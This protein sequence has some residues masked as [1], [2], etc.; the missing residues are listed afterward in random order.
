[1]PR[2][3]RDINVPEPGLILMGCRAWDSLTL[4]PCPVCGDGIR[5]G[6]DS[7]YCA[8]CDSLSPRMESRVL[9]ARAALQARLENEIAEQ[10][11]RVDLRRLRQSTPVLSEI[12]RRR[13]WMGY[14]RNGINSRNPEVANRAKVGRDWL[15]S[16]GQAP[17]WSILLDA[18]GRPIRPDAA[19][20]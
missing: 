8:R 14:S 20:A 5:K 17:D 1:M 9:A 7:T 2:L 13:L 4:T 16:I 15:I 12:Q 10:N 3:K 18:K 11:A 6:D 19:R